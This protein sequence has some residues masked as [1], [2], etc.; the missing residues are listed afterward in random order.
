MKLTKIANWHKKA[1]PDDNA[2]FYK[3]IID[4]KT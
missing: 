4:V 1:L 2:V 3:V